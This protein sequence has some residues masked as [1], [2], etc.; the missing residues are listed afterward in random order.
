MTPSGSRA[1]Y[2]IV[3]VPPDE[4][5]Q[6]RLVEQDWSNR[7]SGDALALSTRIKRVAAISLIAPGTWV[8]VHLLLPR[9]VPIPQIYPLFLVWMAALVVVAR[10]EHRRNAH[11][12]IRMPSR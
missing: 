12:H 11:E 6:A 2:S 8:L 10:V 4:Q 7:N 3:V 9:S 5:E 1:G